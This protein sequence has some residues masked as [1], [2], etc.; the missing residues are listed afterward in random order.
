MRLRLLVTL[1]LLAPA[2]VFAQTKSPSIEG[3]WQIS[4][5]VTTGANAVNITTPQPSLITFAKSHY[6]WVSVN[7]TAARPK[8]ADAKDP[9]K[10]TDAEKIARF[11]QWNPFTGQAGR[12][13][14]N[15]NTL[16]RR[17]AVAKN[18]A[19]MTTNPPIVEQ[20]TL[21][22][23]KLTLVAKSAPGQPA[24]QTTTTLTRVE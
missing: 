9:N 18:V 15:G 1:V 8:F 11:E 20:A 2:V 3:V 7:G 17:P 10:L 22:G 24:S 4:S 23:N 13:Q 12:Y 21:Q 14:V 16:T 19:V 5:I 6:S